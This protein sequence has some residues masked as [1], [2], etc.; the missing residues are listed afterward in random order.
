MGEEAARHRTPQIRR[1]RLHKRTETADYGDCLRR[2]ARQQQPPCH[3][4]DRRRLEKE[5]KK[6][7]FYKNHEAF[8]QDFSCQTAADCRRHSYPT[9]V[10]T[11]ADCRRQ[12]YRNGVPAMRQRHYYKGTHCIWM[13]RVAQW[14]HLPRPVQA[15]TRL[16]NGY[17]Y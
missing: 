7:D 13:Q 11:N 1:R 14:M 15:I 10:R 2:A 8:C 4:P 6:E 12:H 5:N 16:S 9:S 3:D 17:N